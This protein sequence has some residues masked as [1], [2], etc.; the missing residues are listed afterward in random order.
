M[1]G[2]KKKSSRVVTPSP[3]TALQLPGTAPIQAWP[4]KVGYQ[5]C[6]SYVGGTYRNYDVGILGPGTALFW[7]ANFTTDSHFTHCSPFHSVPMSPMDGG[8]CMN[9]DCCTGTRSRHI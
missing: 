2:R 9:F 1:V 3:E 7:T 8:P 5:P 4:A 6:T